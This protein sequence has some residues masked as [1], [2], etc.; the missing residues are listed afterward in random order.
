MNNNTEQNS[1]D[2]FDDLDDLAR[3]NVTT[4]NIY[5]NF[6]NQEMDEEERHELR[7]GLRKAIVKGRLKNAVIVLH[8]QAE[9]ICSCHDFLSQS[10]ITT[11]RE[12]IVQC[13]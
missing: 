2:T 3:S 7:I 13:S 8:R 1:L 12:A 10:N 9:M 6:L 5:R 4:A 11:A